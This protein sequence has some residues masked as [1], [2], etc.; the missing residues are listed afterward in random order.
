[1]QLCKKEKKIFLSF[2]QHFWNVDKILNTF[3]K[4]MTLIADVFPKIRIPK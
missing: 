2:S 4:K 1:M 3:K